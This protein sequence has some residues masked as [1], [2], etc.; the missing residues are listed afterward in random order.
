MSHFTVLVIGENP[1]EQLAPFQENNMDDCPEEFLEFHDMEDELRDN[2]ETDTVT[3]VVM[4]DGRLLST[5]DDEFKVSGSICIG[6]NSH[7]VPDHLEKREV[8]VKEI[9]KTFDEYAR[10]YHGYKKD[11]RKDRYGYW[12]NPNAKWDWCLLGGRWSGF[13]NLKPNREGIQGHHR[14]KDFASITGEV[15]EV[16]SAKSTTTTRN[17]IICY[18]SHFQLLYE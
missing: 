12:E 2:Y 9:Y 14:A 7:K 11:E 15:V 16:L 6:T 1:E 8:S 18:L 5:W 3:K 13:F 17:H 10:K 4:P